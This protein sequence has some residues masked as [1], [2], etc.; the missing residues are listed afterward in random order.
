MSNP[1]Q[2]SGTA[3]VLSQTAPGL[4]AAAILANPLPTDPPKA[5]ESAIPD[6][7]TS[8][9]QGTVITAALAQFEAARAALLIALGVLRSKETPELFRSAKASIADSR[10]LKA[11][12]VTR[13]RLIQAVAGNRMER[14]RGV[15]WKVILIYLLLALG[16]VA[17]NTSSGVALGEEPALAVVSFVGLAAG[18]VALGWV[19]GTRLR[20]ASDRMTAGPIPEEVRNH[21]EGTALRPLFMPEGQGRFAAFPFSFWLYS[22]SLLGLAVVNGL[23][24][25]WMRD[26]ASMGAL[27]GPV[28]AMLVVAAAAPP[29]L[30]RN[31]VADIWEVANRQYAQHDR[32]EQNHA[33]VADAHT[34]AQR[35]SQA[36]QQAMAP[37]ANAQYL[38][39]LA[40]GLG[41][42]TTT[43]S[44][45]FG[46][47]APTGAIPVQVEELHVEFDDSRPEIVEVI[48]D[49]ERWGQND[50][51]AEQPPSPTEAAGSDVTPDLRMTGPVFTDRFTPE[52]SVLSGNG[53]R[54]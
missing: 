51:R 27:W 49:D 6:G 53:D 19:V 44:H 11:A 10:T 35:Q 7:K 39:A 16:E 52:P 50:P 33:R 23:L 37:N 21:P 5:H 48:I 43:Q 38:A 20:D 1:T 15:V 8:W 13:M 17:L 46:H 25:G 26:E 45:V 32:D 29:Y 34:A 40:G 28:A 9:A 3:P 30:L 2:P 42:I 47:V 12:V 24:V 4:E 18:A 14:T 54:P 22:V 36:H 41:Q 31:Q